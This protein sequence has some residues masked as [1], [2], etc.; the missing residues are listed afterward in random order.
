MD[1]AEFVKKTV[2][3]VAYG[4]RQ[5]QAE[6]RPL[7]MD[8]NTDDILVV[9]FDV[10][11]TVGDGQNSEIGNKIK[12]V[13]VGDSEPA[14]SAQRNCSPAQRISFQVPIS[15]A[16]DDPIKKKIQEQQAKNQAAID[17]RIERFTSPFS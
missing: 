4:V 1:L 14:G 3:Q 7:G 15:L 11:V 2:V 6:V 9:K 10:V 12:V 8:A 17:Q 13:S 16:V 5:A